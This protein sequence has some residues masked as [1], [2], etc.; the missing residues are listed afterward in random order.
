LTCELFTPGLNC[1]LF[2]GAAAR[3]AKINI[4]T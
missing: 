4:I 2:N 3:K 1:E